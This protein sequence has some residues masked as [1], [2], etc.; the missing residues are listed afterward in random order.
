[1]SPPA[2]AIALLLGLVFVAI[3]LLDG[4]LRHEGL[5]RERRV[6]GTRWARRRDLRDLYVSGPERGRLALGRH[7]GRLLATSEQSSVIVIG[8]TRMARKTTAFTIP[9]VLEWDGPVLATS[10]KT[11]LLRTTFP[12]RDKV[13]KAMVFDPTGATGF[14]SVKATPLLGCTDWRGAIKV[15]H[16]LARS[17]Q[18][19]GSGL[20]D[21][22]FWFAAAEKL[23]QP[24][25]FAAASSG[26]EMTAVTGWLNQGRAAH[27]EVRELLEEIDC[28]E[29]IGAWLANCNREERQRSSIY[30]TA[31]TILSAYADPRV[32]AASSAPEFA[33]AALLTG[34]ANTLY[35][36]GPSSEQNR[37]RSLFAAMVAELIT[38]VEEKVAASGKPLDPPLLLV[39]DEVAN[40]APVPDLEVLASTGAGLGIQLLT[41][42]QD[43][44]QLEV[45]WGKSA[46]S[47][48]NNH[49]VKVF[50]SGITDPQ[51]LNYVQQIVGEAEVSE[52]TETTGERGRGS[53]TEAMRHQALTPA[54]VVREIPPGAG[55]L[56]DGFRPPAR[57]E[58]RPWFEEPE[59]K[60]MVK[61]KDD[62]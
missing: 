62:A 39:L 45:R 55:V 13:G 21:S 4:Y 19:A 43:V 41:A 29:A 53:S 38:A 16:R 56:V 30:T 32:L 57:I 17:A 2:I 7:R 28:K 35:L 47:I 52:R 9:G 59:L 6:P 33:P 46:Q 5:G 51:T 54:S 27:E 44:A 34:E 40:T 12:H 18:S 23:L 25:L 15:A 24:L 22:S 42:A 1:M 37:L 36:C 60:A 3:N 58:L 48:L 61:D 26:G 10:V 8:P 50:A 14:K 49:R 20:N 31:E 11:D